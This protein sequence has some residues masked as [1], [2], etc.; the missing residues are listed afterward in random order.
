MVYLDPEQL[1]AV[2][3]EARARRI[4]IAELIRRLVR[5]HLEKGQMPSAPREAYLRIV[6]L[7]SSG[8]EDVAERHDS[9]LGKAL[10]GERA[11]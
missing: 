3:A 4:S 9:Y 10:H 1:E 6:A 8:L 7:G 11:R 2:R 5:E